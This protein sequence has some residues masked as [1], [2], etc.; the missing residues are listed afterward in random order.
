MTQQEINFREVS[1]TTNPIRATDHLPGFAPNV[2]DDTAGR[3]S[4]AKDVVELSTLFLR[5]SSSTMPPLG[6]DTPSASDTHF[7]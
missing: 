3:R 2:A 5:Y 4:T 7:P 1:T 6:V